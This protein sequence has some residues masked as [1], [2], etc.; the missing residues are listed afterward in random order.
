[1]ASA[2]GR[3]VVKAFNNLLAETL[4]NGGKEANAEDRIAM[5]VAGDNAEAKKVIA[6]LINDAGFDTVDT[7]NLS[8][9]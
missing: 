4:E 6:E 8:E 7:G 3:P 9:S 5:A 2:F 1:M